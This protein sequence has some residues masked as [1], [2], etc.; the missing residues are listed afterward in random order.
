MLIVLPRPVQDC[1]YRAAQEARLLG[2]LSI[3]SPDINRCRTL[4]PAVLSLLEDLSDS[5]EE[6]GEWS[7]D[8]KRWWH[9][10]S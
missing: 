4:S 1:F 5:A 3:L 6:K 7:S 10:C 9:D 2:P 8:T